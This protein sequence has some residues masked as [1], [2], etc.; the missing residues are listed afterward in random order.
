MLT[1]LFNFIG[2]IFPVIFVIVVAPFFFMGGPSAY[3]SKLFGALWNCGHIAFFIMLMFVLNKKLD[4]RNWRIALAV[5]AAV[6]VG[7]GLIEIIQS[8]VGRDGNWSDLMLDLT[9]AWVGIFWVQPGNKWVWLGRMLSIFLLAPNFV[10]VLNEA[11][12]EYV[13]IRQFP[14]LAGFE[15]P[16]ELLGQ[17]RKFELSDAFYSEGTHSVKVHLTTDRYSGITFNRL[18]NDWSSY[19]S[20]HFDIYNP[21]S[22]SFEMN[23][24]INDVQHQL[25]GWRAE[26]RF[27]GTFSIKAGWNHIAIFID[28][29]QNAPKGRKMNLAEIS[30]LVIFAKQLPKERTIYLDNLHLE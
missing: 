30:Q 2:K 1:S 25:R 13:A 6:F 23:I 19:K 5:G 24:R 14:L 20:L 16:L 11:R 26:D 28:D 12:Y 10:I 3:S 22:D 29:I 18:F 7:G 15:S 8:Y 4:F 21:E 27:S 9:G 17:K